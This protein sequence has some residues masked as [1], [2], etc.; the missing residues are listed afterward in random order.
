MKFL[1]L[2]NDCYK[3]IRQDNRV[4]FIRGIFKHG[5][6]L[7]E[8]VIQTVLFLETFFSNHIPV[9]TSRFF[10]P[11]SSKFFFVDVSFLDE[12]FISRRLLTWTFCRKCFPPHTSL[13]LNFLL[14]ERFSAEVFISVFFSE[15]ILPCSSSSLN[16][17]RSEFLPLWSFLL[18]RLISYTYFFM[19]F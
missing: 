4:V 6:E 19:S 15:R 5:S 16:A 8:F 14:A 11:Y 18:G 3:H 9:S 12:H 10:P 17:L 2:S 7:S 1:R 13:S